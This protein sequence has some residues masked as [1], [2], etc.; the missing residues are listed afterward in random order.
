MVLEKIEIILQEISNFFKGDREGRGI[1]R[2]YEKIPQKYLFFF[3]FVKDREEG[4]E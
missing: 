2:L 1:E 4:V 3:F